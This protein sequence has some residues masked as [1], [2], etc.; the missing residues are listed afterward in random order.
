LPKNRAKAEVLVGA[1]TEVG[2][3]SADDRERI[4]GALTEDLREKSSRRRVASAQAT[5]VEE[6]LVKLETQT[7]V[8][9][10]ALLEIYRHGAVGRAVP[11]V[12]DKL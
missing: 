3:L 11:A 5:S 6:R 1:T 2:S 8:L 10:E 12:K 7:L 9:Q 4:V